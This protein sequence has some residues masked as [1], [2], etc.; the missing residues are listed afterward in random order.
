MTQ[1]IHNDMVEPLFHLPTS[2]I[3]KKSALFLKIL[4]KITL[5]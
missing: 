4:K 2:R 3:N 5:V 1:F